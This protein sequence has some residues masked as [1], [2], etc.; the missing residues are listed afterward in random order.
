[1]ES[2]NLINDEPIASVKTYNLD[3]GLTSSCKSTA[4]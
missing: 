1:M 4:A 2:N 3:M